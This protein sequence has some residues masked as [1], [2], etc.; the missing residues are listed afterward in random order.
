[1]SELKL[2]NP[3]TMET[4]P[5]DG[6]VYVECD[7]VYMGR[8]VRRVRL[9]R[10]HAIRTH[11]KDYSRMYQFLAWSYKATDGTATFEKGEG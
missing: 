6:M 3:Q 9:Q 8:R 11:A 10:T 2:V 4:L 7:E 1:M 5:E